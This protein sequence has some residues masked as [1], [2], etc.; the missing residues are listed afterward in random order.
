M[1]RVGGQN[2]I[3]GGGRVGNT[4]QGSEPAVL[5]DQNLISQAVGSSLQNISLTDNFFTRLCWHADSYRTCV[6][7]HQLLLISDLV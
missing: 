3:P 4:R 5:P 6:L 2:A 7:N 1:A